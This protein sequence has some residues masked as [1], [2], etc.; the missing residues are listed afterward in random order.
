MSE[1]YEIVR[2]DELDL[3]EVGDNGLQ[4]RPI[5]RRV[6]IRAF[7]INAYTSAHEGGE[8][9]ATFRRVRARGRG[10]RVAPSRPSL[11]RGPFTSFSVTKR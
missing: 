9:V 11:D 2:L 7:G 8:I 3:I 1:R 5:R 4:W 6:D 10:L